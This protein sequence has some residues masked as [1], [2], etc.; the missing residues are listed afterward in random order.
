[1][2]VF[3]LVIGLQKQSVCDDNIRI[4][5][6]FTGDIKTKPVED[7]YSIWVD[8]YDKDSVIH[9]VNTIYCSRCKRLTGKDI[10]KHIKSKT[11]QKYKH[12]SI[13]NM[14]FFKERDN[15]LNSRF[16]WGGKYYDF[17]IISCVMC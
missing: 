9:E 17:D 3:N 7:F 8:A 13:G 1:M 11:H 2:D 5:M 14:G 10:N 12:Q 6:D 16:R 4:I 15:A